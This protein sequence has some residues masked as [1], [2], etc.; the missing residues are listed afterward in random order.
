[1]SRPV[2]NRHDDDYGGAVNDLDLNVLDYEEVIRFAILLNLDEYVV[3]RHAQ[4]Y[5]GGNHIDD[6]R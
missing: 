6:L 2:A 3:Q 5:E 4:Y 1:M